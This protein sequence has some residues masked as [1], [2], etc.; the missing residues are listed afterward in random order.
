[1]PSN[2]ILRSAMDR[3]DHLRVKIIAPQHGCIITEHPRQYIDILRELHCGEML[4]QERVPVEKVGGYKSMVDKVLDR[5][6]VIY[7]DTHWRSILSSEEVPTEEAARELW[8]R[9]FEVVYEKKGAGT[10]SSIEP[11]VRQLVRKHTIQYPAIFLSRF[12]DAEMEREVIT[13]DNI[14]LR[15]LLAQQEQ[16]HRNTERIIMVD[17]LTGLHNNRYFR[18]FIQADLEREGEPNSASLF[19]GLDRL[20]KINLEYGKEEGDNTIVG[21]S[22]LLDNFRKSD[23]A[24]ETHHIF[25][26]EGPNFVYYIP[27]AGRETALETANGIRRQ[28]EESDLF[29][30]K[31]TV[32]LG[33]LLT[34][35]IIEKGREYLEKEGEAR[36]AAAR[37]RGGGS[38]Y[39]PS[40]SASTET[41]A[42]LI[43]IIDPDEYYI[44]MVS[45]ELQQ[46]GYKAM[47]RT[48]GESGLELI[49]ELNPDVIISELAL[50][51]IDGIKLKTKLAGAPKL[52]NIPFILVSYMKD[53]EKVVQAQKAGIRHYF[54]KPVSLVELTGIVDLVRSERTG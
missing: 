49:E 44:K 17:P 46:Q 25:K 48:N 41:G 38:V 21:L 11:F 1:M 16:Q 47:G 13:E 12:F 24:R 42:P 50:P 45:L 53:D 26:M 18:F 30:E 19:I 22:Y 35:E 28:V 51:M 43:L 20:P 29:I 5:F 36:I 9:L 3:L 23:A 2:A 31:I 52:Q 34:I 37:R 33:I 27:L 14:R 7:P 6:A 10:I 15:A 54:R 40:T 39:I 32:S 4:E 8:D